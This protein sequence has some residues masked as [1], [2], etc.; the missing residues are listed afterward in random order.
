MS[1]VLTEQ[2]VTMSRREIIRGLAAGSVFAYLG[3]C[4]YN[5]EIGRS[6]LLLVS[7]GQ[8]AQM[9][10]SSWADIKKQERV[11]T[12][13]RYVNRA[14]TVMSRI[15]GAAGQSPT[16]WDFQVFENDTR[17]AFALPGNRVGFYTG[18]LDMMENDSQLATVGGHE[19]AHV[20]LN[21]SAERYSQALVATGAT[22]AASVAI[23]TSDIEN[24]Q[25]WAAAF[26]MG[27]QFGVLLPY[28]RRHEFEADRFGLRYMHAAG[29]DA[30]ESTRFWQTMMRMGG[31]K[32]PAYLSTH[33]SD[34][35][36]I[37]QLQRE[38][39]V[40]PPTARG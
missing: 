36:R 7:S 37:A 3:G 34:E 17:N 33:P 14:R 11:S 1:I 22:A 10:A 13:P 15:V 29:Y 21:H 28:S 18:L 40:L 30:R 39:A 20:R 31:Q 2:K 19:Y 26:G 8:I 9:A 6:Q 35:A 38:I 27:V 5:E 23:A 24:K 16:A 32:P 25:A 4:T 12:D